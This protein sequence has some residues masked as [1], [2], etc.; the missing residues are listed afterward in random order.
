MTD[1][2]NRGVSEAADRS[3]TG[4][5]HPGE[6]I[7]VAAAGE[8]VYGTF[9]FQRVVEQRAGQRVDDQ[10]AGEASGANERDPV[11]ERGLSSRFEA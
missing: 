6:R 10:R 5:A 8:A 1:P 3:R 4:V 11:R 7:Q 9:A 2:R